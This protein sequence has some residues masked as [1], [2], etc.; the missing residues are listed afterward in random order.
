MR[1]QDAL[2]CRVCRYGKFQRRMAVHSALHLEDQRRSGRASPAIWSGMLQGGVL[3]PS[4][5]DTKPIRCQAFPRNQTT[6]GM[7]LKGNGLA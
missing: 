4:G 1:Y 2:T 6:E 7:I 3:S 5:N